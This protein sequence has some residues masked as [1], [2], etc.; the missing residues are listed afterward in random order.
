MQHVEILGFTQKDIQAYFDRNMDPSL[1][2]GL[3]Q[4]L[5]YYP[6]ISQRQ[7]WRSNS[8]C[9]LPADVYQQLCEIGRIAYEGI[10]QDEE[11]IFSDLPS[12][13]NSLD[14]MQCVPELYVD[15]VGA[16]SFNFLHLT[17]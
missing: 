7:S 11:V 17:L 12:D 14:L 9:D 3:Q 16:E 13:F 6:H 4:Y 10:L 8:F 5:T 2:Q 1:L 15:A